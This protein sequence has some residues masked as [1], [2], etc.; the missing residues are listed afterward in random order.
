MA[1]G[2]AS[3]WLQPLAQASGAPGQISVLGRVSQNSSSLA[4]TPAWAVFTMTQPPHRTILGISAG[5]GVQEASGER[6]KQESTNSMSSPH[7]PVPTPVLY[8]LPSGKS[9]PG[10]PLGAGGVDHGAWAGP[11]PTKS[12]WG[13][14]TPLSLE[15]MEQVI[16]VISSSTTE[17][18]H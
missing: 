4:G 6:E 10:D 5:D 15:K 8:S 1:W 16:G 11:L 18:M 13:L 2:W 9:R 7:L 12:S 17:C 14:H 3:L